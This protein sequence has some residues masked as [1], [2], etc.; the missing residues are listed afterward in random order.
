[1]MYR[2]LKAGR[3]IISLIFLLV[4]SFAFID[5]TS[6]LS[7]GIINGFTWLQFIPS[8]MK[9]IDLLALSAAGFIVVLA[10]S[11]LVGRVYCSTVCPLGI[12]QDVIAWFSKR[13]KIRKKVYRF[14]KPKNWLRYGFLALAVVLLLL[15]T[16]LFFNLLDPFS[17]F[18][19]IFSDLVRPGYA[20][21]NNKLSMLLVSMK[22]YGVLAPAELRPV[23]LL[24]LI[25]PVLFLVLVVWLSLTKGRL[26]C[27]TVCPVG[28]ILGL[29]SRFSLFRIAI[30]QSTCDRCG[31]CSVACKSS[32]INIKE[33]TVDFSR[34]VSCFNCLQVCPHQSITHKPAWKLGKKNP[35]VTDTGKREFLAQTM[36]MALS[37][38][39]IQAAGETGT[40]GPKNKKPSTIKE[41]KNFPVSPPGSVSL[42]HF[43]KTCTACHLCVTACP[44]HVL[45][46]AMLEYGLIGL[47]QPRMD[48]HAAY[49]NH[50]CIACTLVCP[51]GAILPLTVEKKKL[52]QMGKVV[53]VKENCIPYVE[54][55]ACG[56]CSEHCPTQA[57]KMVTFGKGNL[58]MPET[59]QEICVGCGA[60]EDACPVRPFR[61]IYVDG[62]PVQLVAK[63]P[64]TEPVQQEKGAEDFPF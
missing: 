23:N 54:N 40:Q 47:L 56:S 13:L 20:F 34:C 31:K 14:A 3:V 58:T 51:T 59:D 30:D 16:N 49:C 61:A 37:L 22:I 38:A 46:P 2:L 64:K 8:L 62:N 9:F 44:S 27:N 39:A 12:L 53:F 52:T 25:F 15:G 63:K 48:Y 28:T 32:C 57:V 21:V 35:K 41:K 36:G 43:N 26:Y 11:F 33:Q 45:K 60:C 17:N 4:L 50:E 1:M 7:A 6:S 24:T 55:T 19:K 18:G 29:A 5:F 42:E 10:I